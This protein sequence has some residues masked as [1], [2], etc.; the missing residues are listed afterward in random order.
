MLV[1][2][3]NCAGCDQ[4]LHR[5]SASGAFD[6]LAQ[7]P[8]SL[9]VDRFTEGG[10]R[11]AFVVSASAGQALAARLDVSS[12]TFDLPWPFAGAVSSALA[13]SGPAGDLVLGV[14][15]P[16]G[17]QILLQLDGMLSGHVVKMP[18]G[19]LVPLDL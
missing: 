19:T 15:D 16:G 14:G 6:L 10:G 8:P 2:S 7:L 1:L 5:L 13:L 3:R 9:L 17:P 4:S 18:I 11:A 12:G